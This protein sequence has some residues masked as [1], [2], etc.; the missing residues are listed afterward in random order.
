MGSRVR[1]EIDNEE[2]FEIGGKMKAKGKSSRSSRLKE[3]NPEGTFLLIL[4]T[5]PFNPYFSLPG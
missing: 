1:G 4:V 5:T 3:K 2:R